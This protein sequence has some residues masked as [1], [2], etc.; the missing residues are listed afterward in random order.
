MWTSYQCFNFNIY[1]FN[2]YIYIYS[3]NNNNFPHILHI[4]SLTKIEA[5]PI[6]EPIHIE[7]NPI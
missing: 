1:S 3:N 5:E 2:D 6:P 7:V 4:Y